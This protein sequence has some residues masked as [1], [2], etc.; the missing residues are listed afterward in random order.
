MIRGLVIVKD[1]K[2]PI[3]IK[4]NCDIIRKMPCLSRIISKAVKK[5]LLT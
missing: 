2:I 4:K 3:Y 1:S 5:E